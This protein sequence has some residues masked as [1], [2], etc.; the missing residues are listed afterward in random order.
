MPRKGFRNGVLQNKTPCNPQKPHCSRSLLFFLIIWAGR[1]GLNPYG[2]LKNFTGRLDDEL[3]LER[4]YTPGV[5]RLFAP[6]VFDALDH[7]VMRKTLRFFVLSFCRIK[8][9]QPG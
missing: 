2:I 3:L 9:I 4:G 1:H 6:D 5:E 7:R 8:S